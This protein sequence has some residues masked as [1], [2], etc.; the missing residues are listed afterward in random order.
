MKCVGTTT[1][2]SRARPLAMS[3]PK[4]R[5][6]RNVFHSRSLIA[7]SC[8]LIS[9]DRRVLAST[10]Q[11]GMQGGRVV[12][13]NVGR[14]REIVVDGEVVRT[15]IWK[16]PVDGR[17]AVRGVNL[18]GDDQS[19]RRVHGGDRKAVYAYARE[20]LAWWSERLGQRLGSG[21]FGEN[22]TTEGLDVTA[23]R[24]GDRWRVGTALLEV[25]QPR[26]PCSK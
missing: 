9:I 14:P 22:L 23:A 4:S 6:A 17:V 21:T 1:G 25:T 15:S 20:D 12:S 24:V 8:L 10:V 5:D 16:D 2:T 19:D 7:A 26:L 18:A 3:S 13:V 11:M